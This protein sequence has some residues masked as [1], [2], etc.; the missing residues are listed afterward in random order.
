MSRREGRALGAWIGLVS[1]AVMRVMGVEDWNVVQNNG[2]FV[3][4]RFIHGAGKN[5]SV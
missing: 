2:G 3:I 5:T 4:S 1:R